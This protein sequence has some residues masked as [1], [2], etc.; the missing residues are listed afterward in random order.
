[1][2]ERA[3][4]WCRRGRSSGASH[5]FLPP[6]SPA[7]PDREEGDAIEA[8]QQSLAL[9]RAEIE[10]DDADRDRKERERDR[11]D[12]PAP[13]DPRE[14]E[15][16][17]GRDEG[18]TEASDSGNMKSESDFPS[19][20]R[21]NEKSDRDGDICERTAVDP[22]RPIAPV[23]I[24]R[25]RAGAKRAREHPEERGGRRC[26]VGEREADDRKACEEHQ[27]DPRTSEVVSCPLSCVLRKREAFAH[28]VG[29][30]SGHL[31]IAAVDMVCITNRSGSQSYRLAPV[32]SAV[33][34]RAHDI[35]NLEWL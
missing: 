16:A 10:S 31:Q 26:G 13:L 29:V 7:E 25:D 33:D 6:H 14:T 32:D 27:R 34:D 1:R 3:G 9:L 12:H 4:E 30:H 23:R 22:A 28:F 20:V 2:A 11:A 35:C 21:Q 8:E 24:K 19:G 18:G 15:I 5:H 17:S